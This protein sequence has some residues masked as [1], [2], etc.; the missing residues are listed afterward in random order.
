MT[1]FPV[2]EPTCA[3]LGPL[4]RL[5]GT[6]SRTSQ[7]QEAAAWGRSVL[8]GHGPTPGL[9]RQTGGADPAASLG[10]LSCS[11]TRKSMASRWVKEGYVRAVVALSQSLDLSGP[12][13]FFPLVTWE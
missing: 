5:Q 12:R 8:S 10:T 2:M 9:Q 13:S 4:H 3:A 6:S 1:S 11:D 7:G